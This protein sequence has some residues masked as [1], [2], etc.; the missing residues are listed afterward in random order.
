MAR[1]LIVFHSHQGR[2]ANMATEFASVIG[3]DAI[4]RQLPSPENANNRFGPGIVS[5][6]AE[7][8]VEE[9]LEADGIVFG[10]PVHFAGPSVALVNFFSRTGKY[11]IERKLAGKPVTMFVSAGSGNGAQS[12]LAA[13]HAFAESHGMTTMAGQ[14]DNGGVSTVG[15]IMADDD[16]ERAMPHIREQAARF[17]EF[18]RGIKDPPGDA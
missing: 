7:A 16:E 8:Q 12:A 10:S 11:W 15:T 1:I 5:S 3:E 17:Q 4:L 2:T 14:A 18:V 9:L 13:M 6:M